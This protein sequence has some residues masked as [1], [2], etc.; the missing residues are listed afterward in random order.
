MSQIEYAVD[1]HFKNGIWPTKHSN[2]KILLIST[3]NNILFNNY[4]EVILEIDLKNMEQKYY[5]GKP[6]GMPMICVSRQGLKSNECDF[7]W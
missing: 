7:A 1:D 4:K 3:I 6:C 5:A 2:L